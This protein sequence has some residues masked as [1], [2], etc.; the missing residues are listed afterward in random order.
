MAL[1]LK[2]PDNEFCILGP[3][4]VSRTS[5]DAFCLEHLFGTEGWYSLECA[6]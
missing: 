3:S 2:G 4:E 5:G 1:G 6:L